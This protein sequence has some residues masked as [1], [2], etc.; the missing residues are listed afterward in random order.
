MKTLSLAS[1][2]ATLA[3]LAPAA[4]ANVSVVD[5][6]KTVD[7]DCAKD[8]EVHLLGN[9]LTVTTKGVCTKITIE[10]NH[11]TV[12]GS[13]TTVRVAGNHNT[14]TLAAADDVTVDGNNNTVTVRKSVKLKAPRIS[15]TGTDNH[16][17]APK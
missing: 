15:N 6:N 8:P 17:T 12:T 1:L 3:A 16:V 9:H 5:N 13:A 7:V 11:E 4:R 14:L 10:G 2:L